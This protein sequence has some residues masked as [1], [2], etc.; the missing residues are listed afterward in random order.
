MANWLGRKTGPI[1]FKCMVYNLQIPTP[2]VHSLFNHNRLLIK[3]MQHIPVSQNSPRMP[4][5]M[6]CNQVHIMEQRSTGLSISSS[7]KKTIHTYGTVQL[8]KWQGSFLTA[9]KRQVRSEPRMLSVWSCMFSLIMWISS[10][11]S[12]FLIHSHNVWVCWLI[13]LCKL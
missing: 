3:K 7:I 12:G 11:F 5:I 8:H 4:R 9:P 1:Y 10:G 2:R 6:Y 13:D